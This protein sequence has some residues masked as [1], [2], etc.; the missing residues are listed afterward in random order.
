M[1]SRSDL[2]GAVLAPVAYGFGMIA[3]FAIIYRAIGVTKHFVVTDE[4]IKKPWFASFYISAM[5]QTNAMGDA[6]PKTILARS[7]FATQVVLG[8]LWVITFA[9]LM[10]SIFLKK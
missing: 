2:Q 3:L 5:A 10:A 1:V 7:L 4:Q 8:W 6:T 9:A